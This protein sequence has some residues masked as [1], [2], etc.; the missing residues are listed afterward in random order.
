MNGVDIADQYTVYYSFICKTVKWWRKRFFWML[1]TVVVNSYILYRDSTSSPKSHIQYRCALVDS[2]PSNYIT[3]APPRQRAGRPRKRSHPEWSDPERL[4]QRLHCWHYARYARQ[5][6]Q[7]HMHTGALTAVPEKINVSI[8][9][10]L[11]CC[12]PT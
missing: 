8:L 10:C 6:E 5:Q 11:C 4:N 1:E 7:Q 2:L 12:K 9:T 3:T